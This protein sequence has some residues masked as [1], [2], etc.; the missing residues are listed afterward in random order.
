[1]LDKKL[2]SIALAIACDECKM[3]PMKIGFEGKIYKLK[4]GETL[5]FEPKEKE[6]EEETQNEYIRLFKVRSSAFERK[7]TSHITYPVTRDHRC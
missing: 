3:E 4:P 7:I 1:M 2:R 5:T 6:E